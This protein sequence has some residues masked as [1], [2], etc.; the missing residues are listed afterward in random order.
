MASIFERIRLKPNQLRTVAD[1]RFDDADY[2][3][4]SR[5]N[6]H[7][8][9]VYYLGGFVLECRL[10]AAVLE[11]FPWL[12]HPSNQQRW[13]PSDHHLYTLCY[14]QHDLERLVELLPDLREKLWEA[15]ASG[16]L[17]R[18]LVSLCG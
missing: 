1:R 12:Q 3:R 14:R 7:A 13:S 6:K 17:D 5:E 9:G 10:K 16:R 15:D 2:L 18:S 8:N 4:K 11:R